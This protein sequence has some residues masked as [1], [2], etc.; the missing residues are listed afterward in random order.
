MEPIFD[1]EGASIFSADNP[2][3]FHDEIVPASLTFNLKYLNN[4]QKTK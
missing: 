1:V 4:G 2:T 3:D